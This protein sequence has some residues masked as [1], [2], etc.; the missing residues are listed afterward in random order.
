[1]PAPFPLIR[2]LWRQHPVALLVF[3]AAFVLVLFF[4]LRMTVF[5]LHWSDPGQRSVQPQPWMTPGYVAHSWHLP[6]E[7]VFRLLALDPPPDR[8]VTLEEIARAKGVPLSQLLDDL[9]DA[10]QAQAPR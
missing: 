5:A 3:V 9:N 8:R 2:R 10:L 1:M 7:E 4:A 6:K